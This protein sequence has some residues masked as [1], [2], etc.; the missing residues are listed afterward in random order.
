MN[1]FSSITKNK[2]QG[3][4][5]NFEML[6]WPRPILTKA[7]THGSVV[8]KQKIE[9]IP[10]LIG[11]YE[12]LKPSYANFQNWIKI[13]EVSTKSI[14]E[15]I[16][17]TIALKLTLHTFQ[18]KTEK[19]HLTTWATTLEKNWPNEIPRTEKTGLLKIAISDN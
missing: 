8:K 14:D 18:H 19:I 4:E 17:A 1:K 11:E 7:L 9:I 3:S 15:I 2:L 6:E 16:Q 12:D 10:I 13:C 5:N